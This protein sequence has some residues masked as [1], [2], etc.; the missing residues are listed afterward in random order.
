PDPRAPNATGLP[1]RSAMARYGL[2]PRTTNRP[3]VEYMAA[4]IL[5]LAG[6]PPIPASD[7]C[8]TSP[9]TRPMS[10]LPASRSGTF[11]V[12]PLVLRGSMR[13]EGSPALTTSATTPPY[14]GKPPPGV[15]V[16][17]ITLVCVMAPSGK[18]V[19][20]FADAFDG[21]ADLVACLEELAA[22]RADAR[23]RPGQDHVA[24]MQ[25]DLFRQMG[26]LLH[27]VEDQFA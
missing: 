12:L 25:R 26:D 27:H 15:A 3:G 17:R 20:Q 24:R 8:A 14:S 21:D 7:S 6:A 10:S 16:P 22:P 5:R 13:S 2:S 19:H 1:T 23:G 18:G 9:C 4:M 11:S